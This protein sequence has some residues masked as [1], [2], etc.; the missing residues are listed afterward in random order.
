MACFDL[1]MRLIF[2]GGGMYFIAVGNYAERD[3]EKNRRQ[4]EVST[5]VGLGVGNGGRGVVVP[6]ES[7]IRYIIVTRRYRSAI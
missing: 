6:E 7:A 1:Q 4:L 2:R 5:G 3:E